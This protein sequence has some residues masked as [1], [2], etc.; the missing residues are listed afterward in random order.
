MSPNT[1]GFF[2]FELLRHFF[3]RLFSG[4]FGEFV[5]LVQ[6]HKDGKQT[7]VVQTAAS[8][9]QERLS[10]QNYLCFLLTSRDGSYGG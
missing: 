8:N 7:T 4:Y 10:L 5:G 3:S 1:H 2:K 9:Q 6:H